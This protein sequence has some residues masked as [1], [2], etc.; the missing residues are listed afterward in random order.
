M[1]YAREKAPEEGIRQLNIRSWRHLE[2]VIIVKR[3]VLR[4]VASAAGRYY[5]PF[6]KGKKLRPFQKQHVSKKI[7]VIDNPQDP[8]KT[9]QKQIQKKLLSSV[10]L[11]THMLGGVSGRT[12]RDNIMIH[13]GAPV[14]VTMDIKSFFPSVTNQQVYSV[15][16]NLL[17]CSPRISKVLT[18]LTTYR[19]KLPQGA[20]TS[21]MLANLVLSFV[22]VDIRKACA[23]RGITYSTW[24]D[25]LAFSGEKAREMIPIVVSVLHDHGFSVSH[26]KIKVM[27]P[28]DA[29]M[30][31]NLVVSRTAR[32]SR[33]YL[34]QTQSGI[35]KLRTKGV[36]PR[37]RARYVRALK[38][39]IHYIAALRQNIGARLT[40]QLDAAL[41]QDV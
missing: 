28:G 5:K 17:G 3:G 8:L 35:H 12:I 30:L 25:D 39:R 20:S 6:E 29:K 38:G 11:P 40:S 26:K 19:G 36:P 2:S 31:H 16:R 10:E 23:T 9:L 41:S 15:W 7:R 1:K 18:K 32:V 13:Q 33:S 22:D 37:N 27:G 34:S 24:V 4:A 14:V 21:T